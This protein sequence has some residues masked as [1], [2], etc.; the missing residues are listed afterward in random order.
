MKPLN[1]IEKGLA[2]LMFSVIALVSLVGSSS[3]ADRSTM[4]HLDGVVLLSTDDQHFVVQTKDYTFRIDKSK[5]S[6][7]LQDRLNKASL[8]QAEASF[9]APH[10]AIEL[11]WPTFLAAGP[12]DLKKLE[13]DSP[14][15]VQIIG[16]KISVK[17]VLS[18]SFSDSHFLVQSEDK[19]YRLDRSLLSSDIRQS[20][21]KKAV[22]DKVNLTLDLESAKQVGTLTDF[23]P[24]AGNDADRV[25]A[26]VRRPVP[27]ND[28]SVTFKKGTLRIVGTLVHSFNTP[29]VV[30]QVK[31]TF[32]QMRRDGLVG[33]EG[34][35]PADYEKPGRVVHVQAPLQAVDFVWS[36]A[37]P[38]EKSVSRPHQSPRY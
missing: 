1:R 29:L 18:M 36:Y 4:K 15:K 34:T 19:L 22:G 11:R 31:D 37:T 8:S 9:D 12:G 3:A 17:G 27:S 6:P 13:R 23:P 28:E 2:R 33:V 32:L 10:G 7:E 30:I 26:S 38:V 24:G 16:D 20:L 21:E 14:D 25:P 35:T 5:L